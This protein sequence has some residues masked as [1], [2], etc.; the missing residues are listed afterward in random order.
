MPNDVY[1]TLDKEVYN[2]EPSF[3]LRGGS[4][5]LKFVPRIIQ[6]AKK[7]LKQSGYL[8]LELFEDTLDDA[9]EIAKKEGLENIKTLKDLAN[10][11][12]FLTAS[13]I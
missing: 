13:F 6:I 10:K 8:A 2:F 7:H 1:E 9:A 12:R 5:G 3:A 11:D 4:D